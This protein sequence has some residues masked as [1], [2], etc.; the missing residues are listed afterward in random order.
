[1]EKDYKVYLYHILDCIEAVE[2]YTEN[3][4][5]GEFKEDRRTVDAVIRNF[6]IIGEAS[7]KISKGFRE[8]HPEIPWKKLIGLRNILIHEYMGVDINAVWANIKQ[9][10]APLKKQIK[11][12]I[13]AEKK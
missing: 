1:M 3:V 4:S 2:K 9:E 6:E 13:A 8:R 11:L 7:N 5:L 12:A 10:L